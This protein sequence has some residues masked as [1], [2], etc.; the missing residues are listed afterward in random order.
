MAEKKSLVVK[1]AI[2]GLLKNVRISSDFWAAL[3]DRVAWKVKRAVE[4][5]KANGR[6]TV[7]G[8]DL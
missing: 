7:R 6:K 4:R 2:K 1:S 5:A 8:Y 3:S